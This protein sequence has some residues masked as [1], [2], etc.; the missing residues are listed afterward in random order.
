M[1]GLLQH[2]CKGLKIIIYGEQSVLLSSVM[3]LDIHINS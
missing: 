3:F 2:G 1:N